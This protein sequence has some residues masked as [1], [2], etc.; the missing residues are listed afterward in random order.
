MRKRPEHYENMNV[1]FPPGSPAN[2][3]ALPAHL[4]LA[5]IFNQWLPNLFLFSYFVQEEDGE[6]PKFVFM[7]SLSHLIPYQFQKTS[8]MIASGHFHCLFV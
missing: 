6:L 7:S 5:L 1:R 3:E 4:K 2:H 8:W